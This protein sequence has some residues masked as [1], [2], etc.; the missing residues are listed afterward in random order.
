MNVSGLDRAEHRKPFAGLLPY[1]I[2]VLG[3][4]LA[5]LGHLLLDRWLEGRVPYALYFLPILYIA[6]KAGLGPTIATTLLALAATWYFILPPPYSF[7]IEE[8]WMVVSLAVFLAVSAAMIALSRKAAQ[9][10]AKAVRNEEACRR[11]ERGARA[12]VWDWNIQSDTFEAV[13]LAAL[14]GLDKTLLSMSGEQIQSLVHPDDRVRYREVL[15]RARESREPF[16][17]EFRLQHPEHG[18][19]WMTMIGQPSSSWPGSR[20]F[21]GITVDVTDRRLAE[22]TVAEQREW[23]RVTL[24]SVGDAVIASDREGRIT[25]MNSTA[26]ELTGWPV[27]EAQG[28]PLEDVFRIIN[29]KTREPVEHPVDKVLRSGLVI[30]LANHT[31]L[32]SRDG[33]ERPIADSAAP[34]LRDNGAIIGVVLVFHDVSAERR[35][36]DA[37]AEQREWFEKTLESIGD[38]VIAT[39]V[40]GRIAFMNPVAEYLT[41]WRMDQADERDVDDVFRIVNESTRATVESPVGRVL[42]EGNIA[43]LANHTLLIS[44]SGAERPIDDSGAPIR[45]RDGRIVGVVLVFRDVSERRA[46]E[47]EKQD[48]AYQR[49]RLLESERAARSDAERANRLKD[50]FVATLS[51]ELRTPLNAIL[52]WVHVLQTGATDDQTLRQALEV[53]ERNAHLQTQLISDLLDMSSI[54]SGKLRLEVQSVDVASA[55]DAALETVQ[56]LA[57]AKEIEIHRQV[58]A[59]PPVAA[60]P[61]RLQQIAWNLLSN[62]VKFTPQGGQVSIRLRR[63]ES[64]AEIAVSDNGIGIRSDFLAHVFERFRQAD[65]SAAR[66]FSGLGLGLSIVKQLVELHGGSVTAESDGEGR[67]ATFRVRLPIGSV[68][69]RRPGPAGSE[70]PC[71]RVAEIPLERIKGLRVLV[72]EDQRDT[73]DLLVRLLEECGAAVSAAASGQEGLALLSTAKP[74][75]LICD[76]GL[77][78]IDGYT[79][80]QRIRRSPDPRVARVPAIALT[81]FAQPEDRTRA[82][83]AGYQAHL[84]KPMDPAELIATVASFVD[85]LEPR[86]PQTPA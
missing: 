62:A 27:E 42:R 82:L 16:Q 48:A 5:T 41:G 11:A 67:G 81:S 25:F 61:A 52:G 70:D 8:T 66:R 43:G 45:S 3:V 55:I 63:V 59:L 57:Q 39:D 77:P 76:I 68:R 75:V 51:H 13:A 31:A 18:E 17:V 21:S 9:L 74:D 19:R 33:V 50:E 60:D 2:G 22:A 38:G 71:V 40:R 10:R 83:R 34:I 65:A 30:G 46:A 44:R 53:I 15:A 12:A 4:A 84:V 79:L 36:A 64:S 73:R 72:I 35:A 29:E 32:I 80:I 26:A 1:L 14:V 6:W 47:S 49:E 37:A 28:R 24:Q 78:V 69:S 20:W 54:L 7:A 86:E 58:D 23:F 56:P 85:M